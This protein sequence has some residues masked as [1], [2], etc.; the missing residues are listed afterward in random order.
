LTI[1]NKKVRWEGAQRLN[2]QNLKTGY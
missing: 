2:P 1:L